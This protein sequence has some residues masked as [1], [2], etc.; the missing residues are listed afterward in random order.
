MTEPVKEVVEQVHVD[1]SAQIKAIISDMKL[2]KPAEGDAMSAPEP[3][4]QKEPEPAAKIAAVATP[5]ANN[6]TIPSVGDNPKPTEAVPESKAWAKAYKLEAQLRKEREETKKVKELAEA[7]N[8]KLVELTALVENAK[9]D[10]IKFAESVGVSSRDWVAQSLK[11]EATPEEKVNLL[12]KQLLDQSKS[13][14]E[15]L[16]Q[17]TASIE[18]KR[19]EAEYRT[20]VG[21]IEA[22]VQSP[23]YEL[24][25]SLGA[26]GEVLKH[27]QLVASQ[28]GVVISPKEAADAVLQGITTHLQELGKNETVKKLLGLTASVPATP[29]PKVV[30]KQ[31][32]TN[33]VSPTAPKED[34]MDS[35]PR[36]EQIKRLAAQINAS[37]RG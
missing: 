26:E 8:K 24:I 1:R 30:P 2:G 15:K 12:E 5:V 17:A 14:E 13:I 29:A 23:E 3:D 7:T 10:P 21:S 36:K 31:S 4:A 22:T 27:A 33:Q 11:P 6:A 9:K 19:L 25:R 34:D 35:Y 18:Q 16:A 28:Q 37:Q 20:Y 32:L